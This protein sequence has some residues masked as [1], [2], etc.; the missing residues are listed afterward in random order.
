MMEKLIELSKKIPDNPHAL[1][2]L[3]DILIF[4]NSVG[5]DGALMLIPSKE[6]GYELRPVISKEHWSIEE[7]T[8]E[9]RWL[10]PYREDLIKL[11][12]EVAAA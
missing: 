7:W 12:K 5:G 2:R 6:F 9:R 11:L 8:T 3:S 10:I 1:G 4:L